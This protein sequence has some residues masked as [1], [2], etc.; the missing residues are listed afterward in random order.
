MSQAGPCPHERNETETEMATAQEIESTDT[1]QPTLTELK[2]RF[3]N[4]REPVLVA[5]SLLLRDAAIPI[6]AA[7]EEAQRLGTRIT[8]ASINAAK[9][10]MERMNTEA[11]A[12][13]APAATPAATR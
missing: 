10:L 5:L 1:P 6:E 12:P 9:R 7:K 13:A 3:A 2:Q 8:V 4:V 11:P